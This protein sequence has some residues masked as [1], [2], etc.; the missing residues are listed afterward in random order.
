MPPIPDFVRND[1]DFWIISR[2]AST[3]VGATAVNVFLNPFQVIA[4]TAKSVYTCCSWAGYKVNVQLPLYCLLSIIISINFF[5]TV[6]GIC[7][8][9]SQK[10]S[11]E[12]FA[13][14]DIVRLH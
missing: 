9:L 7:T 5:L 13:L 8:M 2:L 4:A 11:V 1:G 10:M 3:K 6:I 12:K 14:Y